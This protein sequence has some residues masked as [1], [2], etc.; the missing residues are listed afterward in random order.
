MP[1]SFN[2]FPGQF[3]M[4]FHVIFTPFWVG[5]LL[6]GLIDQ[7]E[8]ELQMF[9]IQIFFSRTDMLFLSYRL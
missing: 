8:I 2:Y 4:V 6:S 9:S 7:F 5:L 1:K 3:F